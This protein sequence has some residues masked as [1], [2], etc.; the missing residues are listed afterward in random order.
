MSSTRIQTAA[1]QKQV[2]G[3]G[4]LT[5]AIVGFGTVGRSVAKVLSSGTH[6]SLRLSAICNRGI[7]RKKVDWVSPDVV[8]T[9]SIDS[10]VASDVDIVVELMG[11]LQPAGDLIRGALEAG[12]SVVTAN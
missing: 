2:N 11:G 9:E 3:R 12:T 5:V 7:D 8:W 6:P 10:V 1:S 4:P